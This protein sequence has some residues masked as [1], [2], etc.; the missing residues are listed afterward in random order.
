MR[1]GLWT[2]RKWKKI[3]LAL[4]N[5][6]SQLHACSP[7]SPSTMYGPDCVINSTLWVQLCTGCGG[8]VQQ[9]SIWAVIV[10]Q[11]KWY[12]CLTPVGFNACFHMRGGKW[13]GLDGTHCWNTTAHVVPRWT[14]VSGWWR[15]DEIKGWDDEDW[16]SFQRQRGREQRGWIEVVQ[17]TYRR[18][19]LHTCRGK[20][21]T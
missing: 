1:N 18:K 4:V 17:Q 7:A 15:E 5:Y 3:W 11:P 19:T 2:I 8:R 13:H 21:S 9:A 20:D 12:L 16:G 10:L 6:L 14:A